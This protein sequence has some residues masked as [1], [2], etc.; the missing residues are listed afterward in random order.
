MKTASPTEADRQAGQLSRVGHVARPLE[1]KRKLVQ[2]PLH[3]VKVRR[4]STF[5]K[6][7]SRL[8]I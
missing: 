2:A 1:E 6:R 3:H 8:G 4:R 5:C 7:R